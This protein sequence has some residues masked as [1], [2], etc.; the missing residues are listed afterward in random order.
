MGL[1]IG[2]CGT[3]A[4][5]DN[6]IPLFQA[7]PLVEKVVLSDLDAV[8]LNEKAVKWNITETHPSLDALCDADIDAIAIMTQNWMHAPQAIQALRAGKHVYSAVP[9]AINLQQVEELVRAVEDTGLKYMMGETSY[10]SAMSY[11]CRERHAAGDFGEFVYC[12]GQYLHDYDHGLYEVV[13]RRGGK[14]WRKTAG[15]P[16]MFYPTHSLGM[17]LSVTRSYAQKVSAF[18]WEDH[19]ADGIFDPEV[20]QWKNPFSNESGLFHMAD[21]SICRINEFRRI[22][23]PGVEGMRLYG[24]EGSYEEITD[25]KK[26]VVKDRAAT[27]DLTEK[28]A[29]RDVPAEQFWPELAGKNAQVMGVS[30]AH[31]VAVLPA[32]YANLKNGHCGSHLFL[33]N[34]FV[35]ALH[36]DR[37]PVVDVYQAARYYVPGLI[38][39]ESALKGGILLDVPDFGNP[40]E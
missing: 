2:V 16:P 11:Y 29:C 18:G 28:L 8:K 22:G 24:T 19:H 37:R 31:P 40:D 14:N 21:N 7:H 26:W 33:I 38:A 10:F 5:A 17:V 15:V 13:K 27:V 23:T 30:D 20:N 9:T 34:E 3:G 25:A 32:T 35:N 6:F 39:H 4:F 12:E 1:K 36:E